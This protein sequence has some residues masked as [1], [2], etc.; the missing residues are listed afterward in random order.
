MG[1][2]PMNPTILALDTATEY[3][4]VALLA[5]NQTFSVDEHCQNQHAAKLLQMIDDLLNQANIKLN[6]V[7]AIAFGCGPGSFTGVR[8]AVSI[9]QG[10][11]F[12]IQKPVIP[13][14]TLQIMAQNAYQQYGVARVQVA[15]DAR[16]QQIYYGQY[17][18]DTNALMQPEGEMALLFIEE[19]NTTDM[20]HY[21]DIKPLASSALPLALKLFQNNK[22]I[23]PELA[24]PI[25][26]RNNIADKK[27]P[28]L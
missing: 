6:D 17:A 5:N 4:T 28:P 14:P 10:L 20:M 3:C 23:S 21:P 12:G 19:V 25:Y 1:C 7:D 13:I 22:A 15:L 11:A 16:M 24:Q 26:L 27:K 9:A 18:L 2:N 8:I